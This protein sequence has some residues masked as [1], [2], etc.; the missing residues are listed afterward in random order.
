MRAYG[1]LGILHYRYNVCVQGERNGLL[2]TGTPASPSVRYTFMKLL[3]FCKFTILSII[4]AL[5][6]TALS[7]TIYAGDVLQTSAIIEGEATV[8]NFNFNGP[9]VRGNVLGNT[10]GGGKTLELD[11]AAGGQTFIKLEMETAFTID[12]TNKRDLKIVNF[13]TVDNNNSVAAAVWVVVNGTAYNVGSDQV[14][15]DISKG[16]AGVWGAPDGSGKTNLE[17]GWVVFGG[18]KGGK[19]DLDK[20]F[21]PGGLYGEVEN[22]AIIEVYVS[23][24]YEGGVTTNNYDLDA[25]KAFTVADVV[26]PGPA[27]RWLFLSGFAGLVAVARR[28]HA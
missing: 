21:G 23:G 28:R 5:P 11:S 16:V 12:G 27:A 1:L 22:L 15:R 9:G 14:D 3:N 18:T 17:T 25:V 20:F 4:A 10:D 7:A 13:S 24:Y 19:I 6:G 2:P 8:T 26:V